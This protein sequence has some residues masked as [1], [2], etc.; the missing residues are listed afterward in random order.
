MAR[1]AGRYWKIQV[2]RVE[3]LGSRSITIPWLQRKEVQTPTIRPAPWLVCCPIGAPGARATSGVSLKLKL[4]APTLTVSAPA[5]N[6]Q[7]LPLV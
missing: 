1:R 2:S 4:P 6:T 7:I 3:P 5:R